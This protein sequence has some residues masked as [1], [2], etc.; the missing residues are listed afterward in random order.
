LLRAVKFALDLSNFTEVHKHASICSPT[1]VCLP[2]V[3]RLER[4]YYCRPAPEVK[5]KYEPAIGSQRL[6]HYFLSPQCVEVSQGTIIAQ[7]PKRICHLRASNNHEEIGWGIYFEEGWNWRTIYVLVVVL[8]LFSLVFGIVW[9][10][11]KGD[12]QGAFTISSF[13]VTLG[14]LLLGYIVVKT[15]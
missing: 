3:D 15:V 9:S 14:S 11:T 1:C 12:I 6:T 7:L 13:C 10:I 5:P 4:E 2:P 8:T